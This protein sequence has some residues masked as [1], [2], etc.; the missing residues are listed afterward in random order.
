LLNP[1]FLPRERFQSLIDALVAGGHAVY[2]PRVR[3]GV[4]VLDRLADASELPW[5]VID[6][7]AP[8]R[9][10]LAS[11][12][13]Q[14]CFG[15]NQA[16]QGLK[17]FV[18]APHEAVWRVERSP[19]GRLRFESAQ[20]E[21]Q[22]VA[23]I[24]ARACDL[25]GL[26][27]L[28]RHFLG[29]A[30]GAGAY[31]ARRAALLIVGV[32]CARSAPTC[33]CASTGD[34]PALQDGYDIGLSEVD[35]GFLVWAG[36]DAGAELVASLPIEEAEPQQLQ[37]AAESS[38]AA[39]AA[40]TRSLPSRHL[41]RALFR[42]L[43]HEQWES[44]G[45]RCLACGNCTAVCPT[46]F[47]HA[48]RAEPAVGGEQVEQAREWDSC[49]AAGHS[50]LHGSPLRADRLTRYRQWLTHKLAAWHAQYGRSGCV[51]CGRCITWCPAG[52]DLTAEVEALVGD[53]DYE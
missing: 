35:E 34:G 52:I 6:H 45:R 7:P 53:S 40:Q 32:D 5:G 44:A 17:P 9:Y 31:A 23:I 4:V 49:F 20:T 26:A 39:A 28:D 22:R 36:S 19:D 12:A 50:L 33:F 21:P 46:C 38:S 1:A 11:A 30:G 13:G 37:A 16:A 47:C 10:A 25:A 42:V 24:G 18:F 48:L 29:A 41:A 51:G 15:W 3:G 27:L 43:D 14:R 2:G 8:G